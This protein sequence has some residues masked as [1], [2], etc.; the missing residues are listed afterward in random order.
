MRVSSGKMPEGMLKHIPSLALFCVIRAAEVGTTLHCK[1]GTSHIHLETWL[2]STNSGRDDN[3]CIA[4]YFP[5]LSKRKFLDPKF[6]MPS[7]NTAGIAVTDS[8][9]VASSFLCFLPFLASHQLWRL[10]STPITLF[11]F[12][13]SCTQQHLF[14]F[15]N[16]ILC[17]HFL[18]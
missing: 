4:S 10:S 8:S 15:L 3:H 11:T 16:S 17:L 13:L 6:L 14:L 12:F 1:M 7:I 18:F 2:R 9:F 5:I